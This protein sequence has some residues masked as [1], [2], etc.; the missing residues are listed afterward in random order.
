MIPIP[1]KRGV[2]DSPRADLSYEINSLASAVTLLQRYNTGLSPDKAN[3][4][5]RILPLS[6]VAIIRIP[7]PAIL[8]P[9]SFKFSILLPV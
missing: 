5:P 7:C 8:N 4:V 2:A 9:L 6:S 3:E 1:A